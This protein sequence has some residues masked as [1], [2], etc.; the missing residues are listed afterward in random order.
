MG[1]E[2]AVTTLFF[3]CSNWGERYLYIPLKKLTGGFRDIGIS[4]SLE[5]NAR[6]GRSKEI[7][8]AKLNKNINTYYK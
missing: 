4:F 5:I 8:D 1:R 3:F 7:V 2:C 6:S